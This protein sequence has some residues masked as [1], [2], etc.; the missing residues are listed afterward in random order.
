MKSA[1]FK[2]LSTSDAQQA[3]SERSVLQSIK[4]G[5]KRLCEQSS[6]NVL[7]INNMQNRHLPNP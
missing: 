2:R 3:T 4:V 6:E 1:A 7:E 5:G